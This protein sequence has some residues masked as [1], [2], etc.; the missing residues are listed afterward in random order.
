MSLVTTVA[1]VWFSWVMMPI[2][3]MVGLALV[4]CAG[5]FIRAMWL[6]HKKGD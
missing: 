1:T 5:S 2:I 6:H 3:C 4:Y